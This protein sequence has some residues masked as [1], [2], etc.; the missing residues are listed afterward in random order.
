MDFVF[1]YFRK[2]ELMIFLPVAVLRVG[3]VSLMHAGIVFLLSLLC[4]CL[5]LSKIS[6]YLLQC[7]HDRRP[8]SHNDFP[9]EPAVLERTR[10]RQTNRQYV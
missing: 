1:L 6:L 5:Y 2:P 3:R 9:V 8:H 4:T 10:Y 7:P